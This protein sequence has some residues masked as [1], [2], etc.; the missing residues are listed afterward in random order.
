[1]KKRGTIG[2]LLLGLILIMATACGDGKEETNQQLVEVVHGDLTV[3]GRG[4]I[5]ASNEAR[6]FFG[7]SGMIDKIFVDEG[8][9]VA[10]GEVLAELDAAPLELALIQA[11]ATLAQAQATLAQAQATLAQAEVARIQAQIAQAP[12]QAALAQAQVTLIQ[13]QASRTQAQVAFN[14]A[15]DN[16]EDAYDLYRRLKR[17]LSRN[18]SKL[19]DAEIAFEIAELEFEVAETQ[20]VA[21][22]LQLETAELEFEVA[23]TQLTVVE[24]QLEA[25]NLQLEAANL[26]L[27]AADLQVEAVERALEEAQKQL[28]K[29]TIT[30]P[31]DG[32]VVSVDVD[33]GD[34]VSTTTPIV[35]LID[36]KH[37]ELIVRIDE[38][39]IA[40]VKTE[41]KV[42]I[43]VDALPEAKLEGQVTFISPVAREPVGVVLFEDEDE[44]KSYEVKI[45]FDIPENSPIRAG[46]SA[47]AEIIVE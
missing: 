29:V 3:S 4:N 20:L 6:G 17:W 42:M 39:D 44:E 25:A 21:A 31:F 47:T 19:E 28:D 40:K 10:K 34:I 32:V 41:Q 7:T 37:M 8:D 46:M 14:M 18:D 35:Y 27:E 12:V 9:E 38:L 30:A 36:L 23:E 1:M 2:I 11:Q 26:Q 13:A 33:E 22:D 24:P 16:L 15:E 45:D 43:S 5:Y